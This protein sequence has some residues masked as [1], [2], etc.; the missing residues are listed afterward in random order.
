M[1]TVH[2]LVCGEYKNNAYLIWREDRG[3]LAVIDP[4]DD[5]PALEQAVLDSGRRLTDILLTHGHFD[6]LLAA[7]PLREKFG[8][9]IHIHPLD[10][11]MLKDAGAAMYDAK[12]CR[13]PFTPADS[14]APYP[15]GDE[16]DLT[17]AGIDFHGLHTPGH[18]PGGVTL[19]A[20]DSIFTGDTLFARG[21][22]R[23]DFPGGDLH[24][25]MHSLRRVLRQPGELTA[26]P[27]HG[28]ADNLGEIAAR[29]HIKP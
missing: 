5:L 19:T 25:L 23:Y 16:F 28:E 12:V 7:A 17:A 2:S 4:G 8:A 3:D 6:H 26:R 22:G 1:L 11:A 9:R 27:G 18:T 29:W 14:D 20:G 10:A 13:L 15:L 21:Y 24:A